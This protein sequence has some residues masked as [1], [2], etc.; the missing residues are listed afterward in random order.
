MRFSWMAPRH[1]TEP[2]QL[3][4]GSVPGGGRHRTVGNVPDLVLAGLLD[5]GGRCGCVEDDWFRVAHTC[6][7]FRFDLSVHADPSYTDLG[8]RNAAAPPQR[9][10]NPDGCSPK[11]AAVI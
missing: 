2:V 9:S 10:T 8:G 4:V 7:S 1:P 6:S 5:A 11:S 3:L